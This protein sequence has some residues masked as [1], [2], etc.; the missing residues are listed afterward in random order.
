MDEEPLME[1]H[2]LKKTA[3]A[4]SVMVGW[5]ERRFMLT[6]TRLMYF[7]PNKQQPKGILRLVD[8]RSV[9]QISQKKSG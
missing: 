2:L 5:R 8:L 9:E 7:E 4:T 6:P 1:G 3:G